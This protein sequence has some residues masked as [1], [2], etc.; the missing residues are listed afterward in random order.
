MRIGVIGASGFIGTRFLEYSKL[1]GRHSVLAV[2]RSPGSLALPARF[3]LDAAVADP[4]NEAALTGALC[5]CDRV[6]HAA[7]GDRRQIV[8]MA[9]SIVRACTRA[10]VKRLV[11]L[12]SASVHTQAPQPGTDEETPLPRRQPMPYNLA[13][14]EAESVIGR[15]VRKHSQGNLTVGLLRPGVVYGPRSRWIADIAASLQAKTAWFV[16]GGRGI[17]NGIYVDNL[18]HAIERA[19]VADYSGAEAFLVGDHETYS[20]RTLYSAIAEAVSVDLRTVVELDPP[21]FKVTAAER[22]Q[23]ILGSTVVQAGLPYLPSA[24]KDAGRRLL[25]PMPGDDPLGWHIPK[26]PEPCP[27]RELALLQQCLWKFPTAKAEQVLDY[28]PQ[29]SFEDGMRRSI[30]WL[31]FAGLI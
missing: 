30:G 21:D 4:C 28:H 8:R 7:L 27:T 22:V 15:H 12:S 10:G 14:A 23:G 6:L 13:K 31:R 19:L 1:T 16:E 9:G 5:G 3:P 2:V 17:C 26:R 29:V 20:W 18:I 25:A 11:V 24:V